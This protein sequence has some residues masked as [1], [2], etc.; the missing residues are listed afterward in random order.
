MQ[1]EDQQETCSDCVAGFYCDSNTTTW[2]AMYHSKK[3][4]AGLYC[5]AKMTT[6]PT[7][8]ANAC[9]VAHVCPESTP[10]PI[11]CPAGKYNGETG[12]GVLSDC[13][14]TPA[15][16]YSLIASTNWTAE[17]DPGYY[18]PAG[19]T[20]PKQIPCPSG[21]YI[22][23]SRGE[24]VNSCAP[25]TAGYVCI[26]GTSTPA[27]AEQGYYAVQGSGV[28]TPCSR[29]TFGNRTGLKALSEC[30]SCSPGY[31]CDLEGLTSPRGHCDEGYYCTLGSY[32]SAPSGPGDPHNPAPGVP[33]PIGGPCPKGF[34]CQTGSS[35][36]TACGVGKYNNITGATTIEACHASDPGTYTAGVGN[37]APTGPCLPGYYCT[38]AAY[39][40][41]GSG[42]HGGE[43]PPGYFTPSGSPAPIACEVG[44]YN[45]L[46]GQGSC[47]DCFAGSLCSN[48][49]TINPQPCP[50]G[51]WC[52]VGTY[53]AS[54]CPVGRFSSNTALR[55]ATQCTP[56]T[57]GRYC[58]TEG[59]TAPTADCFQQYYC[60][61]GATQGNPTDGTT[62]NICPPGKFCITGTHTPAKCAL[63]K[64]SPS[65]GLYAA[66]GTGGCLECPT[67]EHCNSTGLTV[68]AGLCDA[69]YY[70][71]GSA[72]SPRPLGTGGNI[73]PI[74]RYSGVGAAATIPCPDGKYSASTGAG[75]CTDSPTGYVAPGLENTAYVPCP[76][77]FYCPG[78]NGDSPPP[79][80]KGR[81]S[82]N[83]HL[84]S[85]SACSLCTPG[86]YCGS[87]SLNNATG[88]CFAG[89][90]CPIGS[91][92]G[93]GKLTEAGADSICPAGH[94][95]PT[96]THTPVK[97]PEGTFSAATGN[98]NILDCT[99][100]SEGMYCEGDG[101]LAP[102][103]N[104]ASGFQCRRGAKTER[105]TVGITFNSH[106]GLQ[107]GGSI[108]AP[109]SFCVNG[110]AHETACAPGT[111]SDWPGTACKDCPEGYFCL[112]NSTGYASN[113]CPA[114]YYCPSKTRHAYEFPCS[115][116]RYNPYTMRVDASH[117]IAA[118][119]GMYVESPAATSVTGNCSAG[120]YCSGAAT[121]AQPHNKTGEH[122][123]MVVEMLPPPLL[124]P[125]ETC[126]SNRIH[127]P[128]KHTHAHLLLPN[129]NRG[130]WSL[131]RGRVLQRWNHD[132]YH[133]PR[134]VL[135]QW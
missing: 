11:P 40:P 69:G 83:T 37:P 135:L 6:S 97:C 63:G 65:T 130:R 75:V 68:P 111:Y 87:T 48:R 30:T 107:E 29:G 38:S 95:C 126:A 59:L 77:G 92:A 101:L 4:P 108:C 79:C 103:G 128:L 46:P 85:A 131:R 127:S 134:R 94:Y 31:Y 33:A 125:T 67:S 132:T 43:T 64:Y 54:K 73:A 100:C 122:S 120:Y 112:I 18:C 10:A 86:Y 110:S 133:L 42:G 49:S 2:H 76:R 7:S 17:C 84:Q 14:T 82:N 115:R 44:K 1:S 121:T 58:A 70:C 129:P 102:T 13:L 51:F 56:C 8:L 91:L 60:I 71:T 106:H 47:K 74:G 104:C 23:S 55:N 39:D 45:A 72:E 124:P 25:C 96:G 89:Y 116:G 24:S 123:S 93:T 81:F 57:P 90:F 50:A 53:L 119:G 36:G 66:S 32:T 113:P 61:E 105:P 20:G 19:S 114:G 80:P 52:G 35:I 28:A 117:C 12:K 27:P 62:G 88:P 109:G 16:Y 78:G 3:C 21:K 22:S 5:P 15:G 9:P 99:L 98:T 118:P 41:I 26:E 34:W